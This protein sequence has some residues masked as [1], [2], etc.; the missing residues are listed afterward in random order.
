MSKYDEL[1]EAAEAAHTQVIRSHGWEGTIEGAEMLGTDARYLL[2]ADPGSILELIAENELLREQCE[3]NDL[4]HGT[5]GRERV[6]ALLA[7]NE[8]L[9]KDAVA[10]A[11]VWKFIDRMGDPAECDP[12]EKILAE[13]VAAFDAAMQEAAK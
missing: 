10:G 12:A 13:F 3:L 9:R 7:K 4:V 2:K 5:K 6:A 11:L 8:V 1:K